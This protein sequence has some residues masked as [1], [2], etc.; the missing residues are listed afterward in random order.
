[1]SF[2]ALPCL[3]SSL[4]LGQSEP[5]APES[6]GSTEEAP[7]PSALEALVSR[8]KVEGGA[9]AYYGYNFNRPADGSNFIS[10][11]GTTAKRDNEFTLNLASLGVSLEPA[12]VG[13]RVLLGIGTAMEVV[14]AGEPAGT[15]TGPDVWRFLQQASPSFAPRPAHAGG[16][17]LP[18]PHRLRVL[19]VPAQLDV[20]ARWMGE[21][22]PYYQTGLKAT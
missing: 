13:F 12:P 5:P 18:E 19:P 2:A 8:L 22:S 7:A 6:S 21:L 17:R 11:T 15:A 1:M 10:G 16:R 14:H 20:H 3:L 9:D 4:L